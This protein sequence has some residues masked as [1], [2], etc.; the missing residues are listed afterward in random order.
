MKR[1]EIEKSIT[2]MK[3]TEWIELLGDHYVVVLN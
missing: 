1:D 2:E 3:L